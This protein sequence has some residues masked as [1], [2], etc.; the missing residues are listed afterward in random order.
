M[1]S[2]NIVCVTIIFIMITITFLG[3]SRF[4]IKDDEAATIIGKIV[5]RRLGVAAAKRYPILASQIEPIATAIIEST[6]N[7]D[8]LITIL[9]KG[10]I[11]I[12]RLD[13][14]TKKDIQ[15]LMK[16]IEINNVPNMYQKIAGAFLEGLSIYS[17][18]N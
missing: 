4:Q 9:Q 3:C 5:A 16:F 1:K 2:K 7:G 18:L 14:L 8:D 12:P 6:A 13:P 17:T 10:L 15:D 11:E